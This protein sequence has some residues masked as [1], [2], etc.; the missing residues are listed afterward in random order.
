MLTR[1]IL[2][3]LT[4]NFQLVWDLNSGTQIETP[5]SYHIPRLLK[6]IE[7]KSLLYF[8]ELQRASLFNSEFYAILLLKCDSN[9]NLSHFFAIDLLEIKYFS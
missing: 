7:T 4:I 8:P 1:F 6:G 9:V 2:P 5:K 3:L